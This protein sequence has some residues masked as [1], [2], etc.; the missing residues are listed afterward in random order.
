MTEKF[1]RIPLRDLIDI[2]V[3]IE[4]DKG[5]TSPQDF[6]LDFFPSITEEDIK[7]YQDNYDVL[8]EEDRAVIDDW[9]HNLKLKLMRMGKYGTKTEADD[10]MS[11]MQ[12]TCS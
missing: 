9:L 5:E 1:V 3:S 11:E 8:C 10:K 4:N 7:D 2:F 12:E 6:L